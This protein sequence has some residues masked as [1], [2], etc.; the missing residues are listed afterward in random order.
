LGHIGDKK[1]RVGGVGQVF[2]EAS[3]EGGP[4]MFDRVEVGR[5][6]G[7]EEQLT[8]RSLNQ[9]LRRGRV[10]EPGVVQNNH[11][12][13]RQFG[14]QHL[15]EIGLHHLGVATALKHQ[16]RDQLAVLRSRD[17]AGAFPPLSRHRLINPLASGRTAML[18]IQAVIHAAF[19]E[20][21]DGPAGEL[22]QL[23]AEEPPLHLVALAIFYEFFLA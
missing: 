3:L 22:F 10:V 8:T 20:I 17:K 16:R 6:G 11:A 13:G 9:P 18:T 5:V 19:V 23:A 12:A 15:L 2:A 21:K 4:E 1:E 7:Q 14:Q